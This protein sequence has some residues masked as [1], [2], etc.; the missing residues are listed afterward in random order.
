MHIE[1]TLHEIWEL[2]FLEIKNSE[3]TTFIYPKFTVYNDRIDLILRFLQDVIEVSKHPINLTAYFTSYDG[4]R[5]HSEPSLTPSFFRA[6]LEL[7]QH[8]KGKGSAGESGRFIQPYLLKDIFPT[9]SHPVLAFGRHKN[10]P[11]VIQIPDTDFIKSNGYVNLRKEIETTDTEWDKKINKIFWRGGLHGPRI[12]AYDPL[13]HPPRKQRQVAVDLSLRRPDL[14]DAQIS[15]STSKSEMMNYKYALDLDGEVNAW[16]GL[17]WKLLS[18]SVV[19]KVNSHWE[20]WY[21]P[22]LKEWIHYIPVKG[23]L[24]DLEKQFKW[25]LEHDEECHQIGINATKYMQAL[26]YEKVIKSIQL[27]PL[28]PRNLSIP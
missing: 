1:D 18:N 4:W 20:Q 23:D 13:V 10:D 15:H 9:L 27:T 24:S 21:Y 14:L 3:F 8:Y 12:R 6:T 22:E 5:E 7:L 28:P 26:T 16:Q 19:F 2:G 11:T 25:A 17:F